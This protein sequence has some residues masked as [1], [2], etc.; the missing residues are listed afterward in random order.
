M[1]LR[2]VEL[3]FR[4]ADGSTVCFSFGPTFGLTTRVPKDPACEHYECLLVRAEVAVPASRRV[5]RPTQRLRKVGYDPLIYLELDEGPCQGLS[6]AHVTDIT[7]ADFSNLEFDAIEGLSFE[8][9]SAIKTPDALMW[10]L[11]SLGVTK[12]DLD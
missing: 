4:D 5:N 12:E 1:L 11:C 3:D 6:D 7:P 9:L 2:P 8:M 10:A